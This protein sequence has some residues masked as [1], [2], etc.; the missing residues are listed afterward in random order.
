MSLKNYL[1]IRN[2]NSCQ[3]TLYVSNFYTLLLCLYLSQE[4]LTTQFNIFKTM[5]DTLTFT[6]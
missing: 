1:N 6:V 4:K 3:K 2:N 5:H